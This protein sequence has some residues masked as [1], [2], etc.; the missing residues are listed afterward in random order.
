MT[1]KALAAK[2]AAVEN[3]K[4]NCEIEARGLRLHDPTFQYL[5][6]AAASAAI[7]SEVARGERRSIKV[8]L[9][10]SGRWEISRISVLKECGPPGPALWWRLTA[11]FGDPVVVIDHARFLNCPN[12]DQLAWGL[13]SMI[14]RYEGR[15]VIRATRDN[16][17]LMLIPQMEAPA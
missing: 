10:R 15:S 8:S 16:R 4:N 6:T 5:L 14:R 7:A 9:L 3:E 11:Q 17:A 13:T 12:T 2:L 1:D